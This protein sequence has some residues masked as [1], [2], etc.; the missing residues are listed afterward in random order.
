[1]CGEHPP[2]EVFLFFG[3]P[4]LASDALGMKTAVLRKSPGHA[5]SSRCGLSV[6]FWRGGMGDSLM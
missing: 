5:R 4:P 6:S 2:P 3:M 1:M